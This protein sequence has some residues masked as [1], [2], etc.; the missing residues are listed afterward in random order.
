[1]SKKRELV[2]Y[3]GGILC[4]YYKW[5]VCY[6]E[7]TSFSH[8]QLLVT[9][10][11]EA[12]QASLSME[13][14]RREYRSGLP[15]LSPGD[16]PNPGTEPTSLMSPALAGRFF[17]TSATWE[18]LCMCM[19]LPILGNSYKCSYVIHFFHLWLI[20]L[21]IMFSKFNHIVHAQSLSCV[22]LFVTPW[23]IEPTRLLCPLEPYYN[24]C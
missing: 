16:L 23:T 13:F 9:P 1:M 10:R 15:R 18:A 22:W 2:K 4:S 19:N 20:L 7:P 11:T 14:S 12:C 3:T 17:T 6:T 5:Y 21:S 24:A 8:V